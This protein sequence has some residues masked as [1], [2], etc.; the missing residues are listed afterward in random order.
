M[1]DTRLTDAINERD[2]FRAERDELARVLADNGI[3]SL[4]DQLD[5]MTEERDKLRV[6]LKETTARADNAETELAAAFAR[7]EAAAAQ[8]VNNE[9]RQRD[10][11]ARVMCDEQVRKLR[12]ELT[13]M[14]DARDAALQRANMLERDAADSRAKLDALSAFIRGGV[15]ALVRG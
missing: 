3:H 1:T 5:E 10:L 6:A 11:D 2:R 14:A 15:S 7:L 9:L 12:A 4:R 8:P 13:A